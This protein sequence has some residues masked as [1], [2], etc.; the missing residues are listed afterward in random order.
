MRCPA[1]IFVSGKAGEH[2]P[3]P[4]QK[5]ETRNEKPRRRPCHGKPLRA[6][7]GGSTSL[8]PQPSTLDPNAGYRLRRLPLLYSVTERR[9][10]AVLGIPNDASEC[11]CWVL[12][13]GFGRARGRMGA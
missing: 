12:C 5:P 1:A 6:L 10:V 9:S 8:N 3:A 13:V 7:S 2:A 4:F 11:V